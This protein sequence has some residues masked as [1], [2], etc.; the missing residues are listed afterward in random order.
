M[1]RRV[2]GNL[3]EGVGLGL[4][5]GLGLGLVLGLVLG[6]GLWLEQGNCMVW[7]G[8]VWVGDLSA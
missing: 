7:V 3:G 4:G 6:E 5:S 1:R 8:L 2:G